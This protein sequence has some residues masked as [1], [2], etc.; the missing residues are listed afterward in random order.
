VQPDFRAGSHVAVGPWLLPGWWLSRRVQIYVYFFY[1]L[2][3][4]ADFPPRLPFEVLQYMV[5]IKSLQNM[6]CQ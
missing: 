1:P 4:I 2:T 3:T 6:S 5:E